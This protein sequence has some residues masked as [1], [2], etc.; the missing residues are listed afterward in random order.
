M[1]WDLQTARDWLELVDPTDTTYDTAIVA[2]QAIALGLAEDYC[3]RGLIEKQRTEY[4]SSSE[5]NSRFNL[6]TMPIKSIDSVK[7]SDGTEITDFKVRRG[8]GM[9]I[10]NQPVMADEEIEVTYTA[11]PPVLPAPVENA[12]W[13]L[14]N[15]VFSQDDDATDDDV[16]SINL[17]DV[18]TISYNPQNRPA[19]MK[20]TMGYYLA[21]LDSYKANHGF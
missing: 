15:I 20:A 11:G 14:F 7:L 9:L 5:A 12:L 21:L 10:L 2:A 17:P 19:V 3:G 16:T 18:G 1:A 8:V 6:G 13:G 4:L